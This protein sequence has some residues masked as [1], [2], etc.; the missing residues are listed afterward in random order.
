MPQDFLDKTSGWAVA[1]LAGLLNVLL[2]TWGGIV[3]RAS[4]RLSVKVEELDSDKLSIDEF[5][6]L[7]GVDEAQHSA[8]FA[9]IDRLHDKI[10]EARTVMATK[11]DIQMVATLVRNGNKNG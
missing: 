11:A 9:K 7:S 1:V 2:L 8:I 4:G 6:R 5:T 10:D 3:A